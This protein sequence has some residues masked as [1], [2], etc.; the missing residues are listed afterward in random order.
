MKSRRIR[1][2]VAGEPTVLIENGKILEG[3]IQKQKLTLDTLIQELR[4]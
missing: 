1:K 3:N 4:E 2:W